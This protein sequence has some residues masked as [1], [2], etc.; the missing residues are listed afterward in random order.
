MY[1]SEHM[2]SLAGAMCVPI[3]FLMAQLAVCIFEC[4]NWT[5]ISM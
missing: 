5:E 2:R 1:E 4:Q 3:A